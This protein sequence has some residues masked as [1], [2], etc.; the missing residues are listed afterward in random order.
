ERKS[1]SFEI[2]LKKG[3]HD[4]DQT[5]LRRIIAMIKNINI[6]NEYLYLIDAN[7]K[8]KWE[9]HMI[10]RIVYIENRNN[11][12]KFK[13]INAHKDEGKYFEM[14][15]LTFIY[16]FINTSDKLARTA[17]IS[18]PTSTRLIKK[19]Q[20]IDPVLY[21]IKRYKAKNVYSR[22]CQ[23]S[24]QPT[25]YTD[26]QVRAIGA[27][28][29]TKY[30]NFTTNKPAYYN[31]PNKLY[32]H[33]SF[34]V[35][36]HPKN[37]CMP[38]CKKTV[39]TDDMKVCFDK[40]IYDTNIQNVSQRVKRYGRELQSYDLS[41][42]PSQLQQL[43]LN[44]DDIYIMGIDQFTGT[45]F[46]VAMFFIGALIIN[47]TTSQYFTIIQKALPTIFA[48]LL[49]GEI[50]LHFGSPSNFIHNLRDL[51]DGRIIEQTFKLWNDAFAHILYLLYNIATIHFIDESGSFDI[52]A[53]AIPYSSV[54]KTKYIYILHHKNSL[55]PIIRT[56]PSEFFA[57]HIINIITYDSLDERILNLIIE[58]QTSAN[59]FI[60]LSNIEN[61]VKN[62][63]HSI[64]K[65]FINRQNLCYAVLID[66]NIYISITY[67]TYE[68]NT[69]PLSMKPVDI[70]CEDPLKLIDEL[71]TY[72]KTTNIIINPSH[73]LTVKSKPIGY[74]DPDS[75]L[76][77]YSKSPQSLTLSIDLSYDPR[78]INALILSH[79][80]PL[81]DPST[82]NIGHAFYSNFIYELFLLEYINF[83]NKE[84]NHTLRASIKKIF[85]HS[86]TDS[87]IE[88]KLYDLLSEF[89]Q[90]YNEIFNTYVVLKFHNAD[91]KE[92]INFIDNSVFS[93][94][95][96]T[97]NK[98]YT[99]DH[100]EIK[101]ILLELADKLFILKP[102]PETI[103]FPNIY[104]ACEYTKN[105]EV[106]YCESKKLIIDRPIDSMIDI[107]TETMLDKIRFKFLLTNIFLDNSVSYFQFEK[108]PGNVIDISIL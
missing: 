18:A 34:I 103:D 83:F 74:I 7:I 4:F 33:L 40:H 44:Y 87:D 68:P 59:L 36:A 9:Q 82:L 35:N 63:K 89:K 92:M 24:R 108:H 25:V 81:P 42:L 72:N 66:S 94:D 50:L 6:R 99:K 54:L 64:T 95:A 104:V 71:N 100:S 98:I 105:N 49:Q 62:T 101:K 20:Q 51:I 2:L 85:Q 97:L 107:L 19:L 3:M 48:T 30:W 27:S 67:S 76:I 57:D 13:I 12:V 73:L 28:K 84:R 88:T 91:I 55:Y 8:L 43:F 45:S 79:A 23:K 106:Q 32:P 61:F 29:L 22:L 70:E 52:V 10:G 14:Y 5:I 78:N 86:N 75:N 46:N 31:C 58:R 1:N 102:V 90:A 15:I 65:L 21:N 93:F 26:D 53:P 11:D 69:Y 56:N 16:K 39:I 80:D 37:Y 96:M 60:N 38:C 77:F 47:K 17:P 41:Q